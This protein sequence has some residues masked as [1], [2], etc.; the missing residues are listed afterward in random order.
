[1]IVCTVLALGLA[2][3]GQ[4]ANVARILVVVPRACPPG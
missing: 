3:A 2:C 1:M 4:S